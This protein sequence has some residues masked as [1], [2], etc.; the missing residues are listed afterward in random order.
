MASQRPEPGRGR[1]IIKI[2]AGVAGAV[3]FS[4]TNLTIREFHASGPVPVEATGSA[5]LN[6]PSLKASTYEVTGSV[7][8]GDK[9]HP[10]TRSGN[11]NQIPGF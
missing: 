4:D 11:P 9:T 5:N 2:A 6:W 10:F 7:K 8:L 1:T 3:E